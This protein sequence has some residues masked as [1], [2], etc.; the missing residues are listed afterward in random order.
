MTTDKT[1]HRDNAKREVSKD[2]EKSIRHLLEDV[3]DELLRED[4]APEENILHARKRLAS[5]TVK[6]AE[7]SDAVA[8][9]VRRLTVWIL[10]LTFV[11]TLLAAA[12]TY[13]V[14]ADYFVK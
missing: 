7:A 8:E 10:I 1:A 4:R 3:H 12:S 5:L 2:L 13:V 9:S 11:M 6:N 14:L